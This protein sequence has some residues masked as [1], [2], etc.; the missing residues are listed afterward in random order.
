MNVKQAIQ[1]VSMFEPCPHI[2]VDLRV[3]DGKTW[4]KCEDCGVTFPQKNL[5]K[6]REEWVK[7]QE[8]IDVISK[9]VKE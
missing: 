1:F 4:A 2:A 8:A 3:G 9:N 7:F 5:A 6:H